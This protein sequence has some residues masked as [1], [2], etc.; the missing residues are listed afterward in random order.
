MFSVRNG[1]LFVE[2]VSVKELVESY[3]TPLY[4][5]SRAAL[6]SNIEAYRD[7]FK[8]F[9]GKVRL[10]YAVKANNNLSIL[11][12]I[13]SKGFGADVF[14]GGELYM[15]LLAGFPREYTLFNGNSKSDEEIKMGVRSGVPFS[16]DSIDELYTLSE[17]AILEDSEVKIAFRVNPEINAKTHPKIATALRTSKFGIPWG[18]VVDVY[19]TAYELPGV[20]P[21]GIHCHIGS[22]ITDTAPF[23]EALEKVFQIARQ[24]EEIGVE[25]EFIDIGGG[26]GIDYEGKGTE[27]IPT[28]AQLIEKLLPVFEDGVSGLK[29]DPELWLEPGR[30]IVGN[31]T[32]LLTRVNAV[33]RSYKNFVAVDAG[34]NLLL[35]PA[36]YGAYHRIA[37]ANK[38]D[39]EAEEVYTIA[40]PICESGDILGEDRKLPKVEKGDIIAIFDT[41]AY[42]FAMSSQYN[43]RTRCAE[44]L[45]E[46]SNHYLTR[47][48][49]SYGDLIAKQRIPEHLL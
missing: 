31:T 44:V 41:G 34:F 47:E 24:V 15:A 27:S 13:S 37:V 30:S 2:D 25:L 6:E 43:G 23:V 11:R 35:R 19:R 1:W 3:G 39:R 33:K 42:G 46:G 40:G 38:M 5:T 22:Q 4:V 32:I 28:P 36:M 48:A 16:V 7:A 21:R 26:L 29:S 49:E 8:D 20:E 45:V 9:S 17:T 18:R 12:I 14:S 10:L